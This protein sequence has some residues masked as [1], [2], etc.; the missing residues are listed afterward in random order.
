LKTKIS[1]I[2]PAYNEEKTIK[3]VILSAK[4]YSDEIIVVNDN[5]SDNTL[6]IIKDL[7]VKVI[8][9]EKNLGYAKSVEVGLA[10]ATEKLAITMDADDEHNPDDIP[11]FISFFEK[12]KIKDFKTAIILGKRKELPR[13]CERVLSYF[14]QEYFRFEDGLCGMKLI[15]LEQCK[16]L[17]F[18][19]IN[20]YGFNF[21]MSSIGKGLKI[22]NLD[23]SVMP[24]R[25]NA[26]IGNNKKVHMQILNILGK[27]IKIQKNDYKKRM[28]ES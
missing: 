11:E 28:N 5:S 19:E 3:K 15:D 22:V 16:G 1:V 17:K 6:K 27:A 14:T 18:G 13:K 23:I 9:N 20:D 10:S 25:E 2:I 7:N 4:K 8:N 21:L 24:R 26:R 12:E